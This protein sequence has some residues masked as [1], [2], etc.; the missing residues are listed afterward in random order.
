MDER[1]LKGKVIIVTGASRGIGR[2]I[3]LRLGQGGAR[4]VITARS[5]KA[6]EQTAAD[7]RA[8]K[9]EVQTVATPDIEAESVVSAALA[10]Y[11]RVDVLINNAGTTKTGNFVDLTDED[12]I[13]GFKVKMLGAARM[14]RAAWPELAKSHGSLINMSG[15]GGHTPDARFTIGGSVNAAV[16]A[17]TKAMA[18]QGVVDGVQVNCISPGLV[19]TDRLIRRI[20]EHAELWAVSKEEAA[21]RMQAQLQITGFADP[22]EIAELMVYL[23]SPAGRIFHG[24]VMDADAGYTKGL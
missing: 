13:D 3:A 22:E 7:L 9:A 8:M 15:A 14:A 16:M 4:L 17:F 1:H 20:E 18:Q 12:W 19:R 6:L 10:A 5:L 24:A 23:L 11:G 21:K 2:A